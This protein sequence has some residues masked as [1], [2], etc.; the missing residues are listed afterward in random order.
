MRLSCNPKL[1]LADEP[2]TAPDATVQSILILAALSS[3]KAA[4][5]VDRVC[6]PRYRRRGGRSPTGWR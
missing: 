3:S 4:R 6:D 1:L 2:T 5:A